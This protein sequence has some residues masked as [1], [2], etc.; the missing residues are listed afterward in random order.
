M[1][2][3]A[4]LLNGLSSLNG[5]HLYCDDGEWQQVPGDGAYVAVTGNLTLGGKG[6]NLRYLECKEPTGV[7]A[8]PGVI[9]YRSVRLLPDGEIPVVDQNLQI[10]ID[11][12]L[13]RPLPEGLIKTGHLYGLPPLRLGEGIKWRAVR[14]GT[15]AN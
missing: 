2:I 11:V 13:N 1:T 10:E 4:K 9:C 7:E 14:E 12:F 6:T 3:G 15:V 8:P 5:K